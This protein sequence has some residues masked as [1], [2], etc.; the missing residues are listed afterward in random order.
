MHG[1]SYGADD[2]S[3][4][5]ARIATAV[6]HFHDVRERSDREAAALLSE[7]A[8]DIVVD[9]TGH[10]ENS[11]MGILA[12]RPAPIQVSYFG[13]PGTSGAEFIDY[14]MADRVV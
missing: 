9:L 10:T 4:T 8:V 1:V 12:H 13:Y 6:D 2:G 3:E 11:R 7:L 5:R 14:I